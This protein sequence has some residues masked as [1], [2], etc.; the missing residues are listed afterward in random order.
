[1]PTA[2][3]RNRRRCHRRVV[4]LVAGNGERR[5]FHRS[6][7]ALSAAADAPDTSPVVTTSQVI[8]SIHDFAVS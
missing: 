3:S 6:A 1:M 8:A 7:R 4:P 5:N 2:G